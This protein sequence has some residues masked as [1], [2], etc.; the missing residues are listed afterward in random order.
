MSTN[1]TAAKPLG[2]KTQC[3]PP[4]SVAMRSSSVNVV[5]VPCKP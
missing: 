2:T 1:D 5:G 4:S 3:A